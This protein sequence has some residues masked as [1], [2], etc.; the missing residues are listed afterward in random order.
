MSTPSLAAPQGILSTQVRS[1]AAHTQALLDSECLRGVFQEEF[2]STCSNQ[3]TSSYNLVMN[4]AS[5]IYRVIS[6]AIF[7]LKFPN[8]PLMVLGSLAGGILSY[9][10]IN[11][12]LH[13]PLASDE[14]EEAR[15]NVVH[16][17]KL[18]LQKIINSPNT[19]QDHL[20]LRIA[21]FGLALAS[22]SWIF[23]AVWAGFEGVCLG[24]IIVRIPRNSE[25]T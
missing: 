6:V 16:I 1:L 21:A 19:D 15:N 18:E 4:N 8:R 24:A 23:S 12:I 14:T 22:S 3:L 20:I 11:S 17:T 7:L 5:I 9:Q 2:L 25:V 10:R 13:V